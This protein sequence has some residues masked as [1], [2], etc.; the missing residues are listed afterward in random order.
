M[1]CLN[2]PLVHANNAN[3]EPSFDPLTLRRPS[4]VPILHSG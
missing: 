1:A 2:M 3:S 4:H